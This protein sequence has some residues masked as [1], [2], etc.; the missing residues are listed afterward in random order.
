MLETEKV[1]TDFPRDHS[2][3]SGRECS[4]S[5]WMSENSISKKALR[6]VI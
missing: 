3:K 1:I 6:S 5:L 2:N 4:C